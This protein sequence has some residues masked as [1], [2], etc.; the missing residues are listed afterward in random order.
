M[1]GS[2]NLEAASDLS[3]ALVTG[4]KMPMSVLVQRVIA[5]LAAT[6][7]KRAV[8]ALDPPASAGS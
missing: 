5:G 8:I 3:A 2:K 1:A 7:S 4:M 6:G